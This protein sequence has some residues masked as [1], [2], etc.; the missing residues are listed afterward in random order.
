MIRTLVAATALAFCS[1]TAFAQTGQ[2]PASAQPAAAAA[3]DAITSSIKATHDQVKGA[4][5]KS[6]NKMPE[7]EL[8]FK[9]TPEVRSYGQILGHIANA[10]YMICSRAAGEESP[11][12]ENIEQTK[13]TR[14]ELTKALTDAF[15]YCDKVYAG[16]N[17]A[18]G[19]EMI[20]FFGGKRA[21]LGVLAFNTAHNLEHY[22][23]LVTYMRLK[24]IV[25]PTS[26]KQSE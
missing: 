7:A 11:S 9:P 10:N 8:A 2:A 22:G 20:D 6:I 18:K 12:K 19:A 21:R 14:A 23:N 24:G 16:M 5:L 3:G 25:P 1:T 15:A 13:T 26:E 17:D 4:I